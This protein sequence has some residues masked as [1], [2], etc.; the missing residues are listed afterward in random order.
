MWDYE[1]LSLVTY[2]LY[3]INWQSIHTTSCMRT[4]KKILMWEV[5]PAIALNK[6]QVRQSVYMVE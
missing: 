5:L 4:I 1:K 6:L 3:Y 2:P